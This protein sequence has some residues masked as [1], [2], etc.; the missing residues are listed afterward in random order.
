MTKRVAVIGAGPSGLVTVKE[1]LDAGH[2]PTCFERAAG[3]GG[4]FRFDEA[5]GVVWESC[6][7]TSSVPLTVFSDFPDPAGRTGHLTIDEYVGYL[8]AYTTAFGLLRH[9]RFRTTVVSVTAAADGGW[10]VRTRDAQGEREDHFDA[11][12]VCSGLHQHPHAPRFEGQDTFSGRVLHGA[13]Y[14][15]PAQVAGRK[16]LVVGAGESGADVVAEVARHAGETVLSLRRGV[17]AQPRQMFGVPKDYLTSRLLNSASHWVFQTRHPDDDRKR[18][19]YKL[20]FV[21]LVV[22]DKILQ[23]TYRFFWEYLPLWF[24]RG[25]GGARAN[26]E[27]RRLTVR[28]LEASGGTVNEQFGTKS[29]DFVRALA[30]GRCRLAPSIA[31]FER[32]KVVFEDGSSFEPDIVLLCTGFDTRVPFLDDA[33]AAPP[34][35]LH[36]FNPEVGASLV[37]VGFVRPAFGAIPPL[38]ELQA[39]WFALLLGDELRLPE[40]AVMRASIAHW[41]AIRAHLFRPLRGRLAHLVDYTPFADALAEQIGC[42]PTRETLRRESRAFRLRFY[43][44]PFVAAQYRLIGPHAKPDVARAVIT[45]LPVTHPL[46]DLINLY[47]RWTMSRILHAV[48]GPDWAPKLALR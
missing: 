11:V 20:A 24:G 30:L 2:V 36:T 9:I 7:L 6:R 18:R 29:D 28:L 39:R 15:R 46:P 8:T 17:A 27:T 3:L 32:T 19:I 48:L 16:V 25:D 33:I 47:L 45:G 23:L 43:A 40:P 41:E 44:A 4:V 21:P 42:K 31:R 5:E 34:R 13:H 26:L 14:R 37:F 22:L 35:Y 12:A 38:A 10:L 1:L